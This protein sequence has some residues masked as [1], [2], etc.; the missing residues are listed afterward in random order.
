[1]EETSGTISYGKKKYCRR[2][3][4]KLDLTGFIEFREIV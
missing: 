1:L 2:E 4:S 3:A